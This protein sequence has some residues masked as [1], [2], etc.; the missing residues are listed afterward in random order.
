MDEA[1]KESE[2]ES[3][4]S[5]QSVFKVKKGTMVEKEIEKHQT[6][7]RTNTRKNSKVND[8]PITLQGKFKLILHIVL[9]ATKLKDNQKSKF[10][11]VLSD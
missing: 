2:E 4:V 3:K 11:H 8:K 1:D 6:L 9:R 7:T 5:K 10:N